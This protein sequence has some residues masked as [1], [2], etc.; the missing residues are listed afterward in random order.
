MAATGSQPVPSAP[1]THSLSTYVDGV[2]IAGS[3][4]MPAVAQLQWTSRTT[5]SS[6]VRDT[7]S[8]ATLTRAGSIR[9]CEVAIT[10]SMLGDASGP[11]M[12]VSGSDRLRRTARKL[13]V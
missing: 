4:G 1:P 2:P 6:I 8:M 12:S 9:A 7:Y 10:P 11:H 5:A 13:K 3:Y